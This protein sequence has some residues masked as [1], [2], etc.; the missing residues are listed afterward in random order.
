MSHRTIATV[1]AAVGIAVMIPAA[2][3]QRPVGPA[4]SPPRTYPY[5]PGPALSPYL[6]YFRTPTGPLDSYH[7]FVR[8]RLQL[9]QRLRQQQ[10][11]IR[12]QA[13]DLRAL[14]ERII[15][16]QRSETTAPTG[17]GAGFL[18]HSHFYPSLR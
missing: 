15:P 12:R 10:Q 14:D 8:P 2:R 7:E 5:A 6:D 17:T 18:Q 9:Q 11:Q 3:A 13:Q 1:A 4:A 16:P